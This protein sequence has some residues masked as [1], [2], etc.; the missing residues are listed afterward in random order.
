MIKTRHTATTSDGYLPLHKITIK[1]YKVCNSATSLLKTNLNYMKQ[2]NNKVN[3]FHFLISRVYPVQKAR[4][5]SQPLVRLSAVFTG[6]EE[7]TGYK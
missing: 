2:E 3:E 4:F 7:N 1:Y 5:F 6:V